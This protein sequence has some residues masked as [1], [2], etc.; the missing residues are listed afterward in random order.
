MRY[1]RVRL[2]LNYFK[3]SLMEDTVW[4]ASDS[5]FILVGNRSCDA[6]IFILLIGIKMSIPRGFG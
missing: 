6:I 3:L 1:L 2:W 4:L 5:S